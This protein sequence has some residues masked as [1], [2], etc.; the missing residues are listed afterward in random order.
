MKQTLYDSLGSF[1]TKQRSDEPAELLFNRWIAQTGR[2]VSF[3]EALLGVEIIRCIQINKGYD[4]L[5]EIYGG[6][7]D[8]KR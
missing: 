5:A 7:G 4:K 1:L 8:G 6:I 2:N 3:E